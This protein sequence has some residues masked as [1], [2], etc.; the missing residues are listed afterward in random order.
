MQ[1]VVWLGPA[2]A[3]EDCVQAGSDDYARRAREECRRYI[4]AIRKVCGPEPEGARL[5]IKSQPHDFGSYLEVAVTFDGN[6]EQAAAYAAKCD[7]KAP[8]TWAEAEMVAPS[9][10]KFQP[11]TVVATVGALEV[12]GENHHL[13]AELVRRHLSGD[14]GEVDKEDAAANDRA[15]KHGERVLSSYTVD[16]PEGKSKLWVLTEADRSSTTV[17]TPGEY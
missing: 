13:L 6:N 1:D 3:E 16:G 12:V 7:E 4:E 5:T 9:P 2:P 10:I 15:L 11:G 14:W 8:K 17:L